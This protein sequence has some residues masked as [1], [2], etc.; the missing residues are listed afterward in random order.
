MSIDLHCHTIMSDGTTSIEELLALAQARE[1]KTLSITDH[2]TFAGCTRAVV[3]GKRMGITV[4]PGVEISTMDISRGR[5][6]HILC[7]Y[8]ENP[9]RLEGTLKKICDIRKRAMMITIQKVARVYPVP[10]DMI[11]RR[12]Q[13]STGIFKQ[14]IMQALM[15]AGYASE[16]F[17]EAYVK[18]FGKRIGLA[19]TK[20][21]YPDIKDI[22]DEIHD[23]G[24]LAV[25]AHPSE[26]DSLDLMEELCEKKLLD[27]IELNHPCNR[28]ADLV[29]IKGMGEKY[30]VFLTG[31]SD[32]HGHFTNPARPVGTCVT[33][34]AQFNLMKKAKRA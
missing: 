4:V 27:G 8:P 18:L 22:I 29:H 34:A 17:G 30:G 10:I 13:G 6:A 11:I 31:G 19:N 3:T 15:D 16:I 20:V 32:F 33:E 21:E 14:H 9:N 25:L 2:N 23:A 1:I 12:S 5:P 28:E 7:Y 24:G 26:Y